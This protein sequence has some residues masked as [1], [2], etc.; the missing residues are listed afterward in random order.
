MSTSSGLR[1][2]CNVCLHQNNKHS[3]TPCPVPP[4]DNWW[5]RCQITGGCFTNL[6]NFTYQM[7]YAYKAHPGAKD[8]LVFGGLRRQREVTRAQRDDYRSTGF[9]GGD[10]SGG[11]MGSSSPFF[12]SSSPWWLHHRSYK[13]PLPL[14]LGSCPLRNLFVSAM[15]ITIASVYLS[16]IYFHYYC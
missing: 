16:F 4:R 8:N 10:T 11:E 12:A 7:C 14:Q 6:T 15:D 1:G 3:T 13:S 2:S 5:K 9:A